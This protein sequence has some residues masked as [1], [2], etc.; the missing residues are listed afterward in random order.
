MARDGNAMVDHTTHYPNIKGSYPA[1]GTGALG[2]RK[3]Q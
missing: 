3:C 1:T 2:E